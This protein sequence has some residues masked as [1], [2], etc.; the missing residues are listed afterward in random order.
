MRDFLQDLMDALRAWL[1]GPE[2][3]RVP[4]PAVDPGPRGR[5]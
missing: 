2:P 5:R 4:V 1:R 3:A